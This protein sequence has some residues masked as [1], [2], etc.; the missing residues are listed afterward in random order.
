MKNIS[1]KNSVCVIG[2]GFVGL[3]LAA[4]MSEAGYKVHGVEKKKIIINKLK[5]KQSHF[6]EPKLNELLNKIIIKK[7]FTFS[8][9][10]EYS[11]SRIY[12]I[13]VGTPLNSKKQVITKFIKD[14]CESISKKLKDDDIVILRSTVKVGTTRNIAYPILK[15]SK[16]KFHL[17]Y[18]PERA[19]EG[20]A[21]KEL[22][23]LPQV[24]GVF[25]KDSQKIII[26]IFK[27]ITKKIVLASSVETAEMIKLIDNSSRDVFFAYANE[28]ARVCDKLGLNAN[29]IIGSGKLG[30]KR[31]DIARPGLV[32]GPCLHKDPYIFSE[33]LKKY[34]IKPEITLT[35]RKINER[36]PLEIIEFIRNKIHKNKLK[37]KKIKIGL[38]GIAFKGYPLT[39]DLRGSMAIKLA[40]ILK[41][42][43]KNL[44][45]YALDPIVE[46]KKIIDEKIIPE[47]NINKIFEK[48]DVI[49]ISNNNKYF[50]KL[51]LDKLSLKMNLNS[52]IYDVWNL[53]DKKKLKLN[54]NVKY[55]SLG[56]QKA[57]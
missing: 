34:N 35:A 53:Y 50:S 7:K 45:I 2:L 55:F 42:K 44:K 36:Q 13:T 31:T 10:F 56:N 38:L 26:N 30:Y 4:I 1:N 57:S 43:F 17:A 37:N 49:I 52:L 39:D 21:L 48:K 47:K 40:D 27:K 18:C 32:G 9:K 14:T 16:K 29:E 33:S 11:N 24:I 41:I 28:I 15:K 54:N 5:K 19:V 3:T 20:A 23:K 46:R 8:N 22:K 25:N 12:I 6:Y 51:N